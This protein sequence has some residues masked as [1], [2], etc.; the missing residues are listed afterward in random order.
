MIKLF[1]AGKSSWRG[2]PG[3]NGYGI[4]IMLVQDLR[5]VGDKNASTSP[6]EDFRD[7]FKEFPEIQIDQLVALLRDIRE[8]CPDINLK[9]DLVGLGEVAQKHIAPGP[10]FPWKVLAEE[11]FG[12]FVNYEDKSLDPLKMEE[13]KEEVKALQQKLQ[14]HGYAIEVT[15]KLD[16]NT[17]GWIYKFNMHYVQEMHPPNQWSEASEFVL[18]ELGKAELHYT[19]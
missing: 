4:G 18:N 12:R 5:D 6:L 16:D 19:E 7:H 10:K 14:E 3:V 13:K 11:G 9:T 17:L 1:F 15:G 8:R 2:E